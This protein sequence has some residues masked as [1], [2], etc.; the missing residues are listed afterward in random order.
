MD[1]GKR[2]GAWVVISGPG[3]VGKTTVVRALLRRNPALARSVSATTRAPRTGESEGKDY[4]FYSRERFE[5]ERREEAFLEHAEIAGHWYGTPAAP[6]ERMLAEGRV[7]LLPIDVQG[8]ANL[9]RKGRPGVGIFLMAPSEEELRRRLAGRGA[10]PEETERR[11]RLARKE[12][13]HKDAYDVIVVNRTVEQTV[14]DIEAALRKR[15][16]L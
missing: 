7:V 2:A 13:E 12:M 15:R 10:D 9:K 6:V 4:F 11:L 1:V 5:R 16:L 14:A 8:Y 3:G